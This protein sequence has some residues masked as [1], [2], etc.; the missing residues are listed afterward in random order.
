MNKILIALLSVAILSASC[1]D[2]TTTKSGIEVK[3]IVKKNAGKFEDNDILSYNMRYANENGIDLFDTEKRGGAVAIQYSDSLWASLGLLYEALSLC[4]VGDSITFKIPADDLF[5]NTFKMPVP[6]T[7]KAESDIVF[8]VGLV[9]AM[10]QEEFT[11]AQREQFEK[12]SSERIKMDAEIID[13]YLADNQIEAQTTES[14]LRYVITKEGTG[15]NAKSGQ[16]IVTNYHGTLLDGTK[17]DSSYDRNQTFD[18]VLGQGRVISGWDE[19]FA[20]LNKGAKATLYIPSSLAYGSQARGAIIK[21]NSIL[22]F[23]VELVDIK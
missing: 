21:A 10:T 9:S 18:F 17:F 13:Q 2:N 11:I 23:D 14:G 12:K 8:Y 15:E 22:K 16:S 4:E 19:G 3:H 5:T 20:L 1:S 7:I 6:D